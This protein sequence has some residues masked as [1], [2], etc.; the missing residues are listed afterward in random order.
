MAYT[1]SHC[2]LLNPA[3][4]LSMGNQTD[5]TLGDT[6][7]YM[8]DRDDVKILAIYAEGFNDLDGLSFVRA[9][10][11]AV[12]AGK[13]V[14]F[15]K[16]G[17]TPE[18]KTATSGHTASLAGDY[19]VCESCLR[20]AGAM[21]ANNFQQ[22][23]ALFLMA[24]LLHDKPIGGSRI[25]ALSGAGFE[26]VGMADSLQSDD[27]QLSLAAFSEETRRTLSEIIEAKKL[28]SL[29]NVKNPLDINPGADDEVHTVAIEALARDANVDAI[30]ASLT[31][32]SP[33]TRTLDGST[34]PKHDMNADGSILHRTV[35]LFRTCGKP[36]ICVV[37][38]GEPYAPLRRKLLEAG[39]P[40]FDS[41]DNAISATG[42]Y[43][44]GRLHQDIIRKHHIA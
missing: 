10:R 29:V 14:I 27:Y 17:R 38:G 44:S 12:A 31:P 43:I 11:E 33:E 34:G 21:V 3:Y 20:Q 26:A 41:C 4:L 37:G 15:Y 16:A 40:V 35:E 7:Q 24:T 2:P 5:L 30:V 9:V 23:E 25:A 39:V 1:M 22:F 19:M 32:L 13:E 36:I 6:L 28:A 18:G 42:L 8:K